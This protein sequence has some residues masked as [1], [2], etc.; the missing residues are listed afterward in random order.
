MRR[1]F[2]PAATGLTS[3]EQVFRMVSCP[4]ARCGCHHMACG[5]FVR[6]VGRL[7]SYGNTATG[8]SAPTRYRYRGLAGATAADSPAPS[9][10]SLP[11]GKPLIYNDAHFP[12]ISLKSHGEVA[13]GTR[14]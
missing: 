6:L 3:A 2:I 10:N 7:G 9:P 1:W 4:G 12:P 11:G 5:R 8:A 14:E 13:L